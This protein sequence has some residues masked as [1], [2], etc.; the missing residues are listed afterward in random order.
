[1]TCT[2]DTLALRSFGNLFALLAAL[3]ERDRDRERDRNGDRGRN[4]DHDQRPT[5]TTQENQTELEGLRK[6]NANLKEEKQQTR[7]AK[8][9]L[10]KKKED[11]VCADHLAMDATRASQKI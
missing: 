3:T 2:S 5:L 10:E 4:R 6:E 1:M 9:K 7:I 8:S 11:K